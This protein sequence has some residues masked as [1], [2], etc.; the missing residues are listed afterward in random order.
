MAATLKCYI[1]EHLTAEEFAVWDL[2]K[3]VSSKSGVFNM[4]MRAIGAHFEDFTRYRAH[5]AFTGLVKKGFF[6]VLLK[7]QRDRFGRAKSMSV[8]VLDHSQF[9]EKFPEVCVEV[10]KRLQIV[11]AKALEDNLNHPERRKAMS[12]QQDMEKKSHV[13]KTRLTRPIN[14]ANPSGNGGLTSPAS[15]TK[16]NNK[17]NKNQPNVEAEAATVENE[18]EVCDRSELEEMSVEKSTT[19]PIVQRQPDKELPACK[20]GGT[21]AWGDPHKQTNPICLS[22]EKPPTP[23][24]PVAVERECLECGDPCPAGQGH[25]DDCIQAEN[26]RATIGAGNGYVCTACGV[27]RGWSKWRDRK[28]LNSPRGTLRCPECDVAVVPREATPEE[29]GMA[30]NGG[31]YVEV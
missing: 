12:Y 2:A 3:R 15:R 13:L 6:K 14:E 10:T 5:K 31:N 25:C 26:R 9:Q 22:C 7:G 16:S 18:S 11:V 21:V 24:E 8:S 27:L 1:H 17:A 19:S 23:V 4:S 29:Y 30:L 28:V 20:C